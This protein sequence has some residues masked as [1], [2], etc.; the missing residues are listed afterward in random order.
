[1]NISG[2]QIK[3][4]TDNMDGETADEANNL[5]RNGILVETSKGL[6]CMSLN[7]ALSSDLNLSVEDL[8]NVAAQLISQQNVAGSKDRILQ[9]SINCDSDGFSS[10]CSDISSISTTTSGSG[11]QSAFLTFSSL[12]NDIHTNIF[13]CEGQIQSIINRPKIVSISNLAFE[14]TVH[15]VSSIIT[16]KIDAPLIEL[17]STNGE[18]TN[19]SSVTTNIKTHTAEELINPTIS[20]NIVEVI[21]PKKGRGGWP[22]GRKRKPEL[23]NLPPKAPATGYNLYLNEQRKLFKESNLAFHEI[24]KIIG[25]RWSSLT[26]EEKKPYLEKAEED[27]KRYREELRQYRQSDAYRAYLTKKRKKRLQNN[28]LSESDMD[29]TDDFD[30]EDNEELYCRTC[31][32][33]FHNLHNKRE[34]LQGKQHL[35]S[36]AGDITRELGSDIEGVATTSTVS[37]STSLDES[38]LD[39]MPN[40]K[41]TTDGQTNTSCNVYDAMANLAAI[42]SKRE[43]EIKILQNRLDESKSQQEALCSQLLQLNERHKKLQKDLLQL[44]ENEKNMESRVFHLWQVPSWFIIT[45]FNTDSATDF[46]EGTE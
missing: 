4:K 18:M 44:K 3:I 9:T 38:S 41:N 35:Q 11:V 42:V 32:Q 13:N 27:K 33:W 23:L 40:L 30:E 5:L 14:K 15:N 25:N 36:V 17:G 45:D 8:R 43:K 39:G 16:E 20:K 28:V 31:D 46:T 29:A 19:K 1:M 34:H 21:K 22:K 37:F 7:D 10:E 12:S 6:I 24:T 26:L 2:L